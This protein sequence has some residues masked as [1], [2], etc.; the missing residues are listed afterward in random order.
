MSNLNLNQ[1]NISRSFFV[2]KS[3]SYPKYYDMEPS[4]ILEQYN[5]LIINHDS[6]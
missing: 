2:M 6:F 1:K 4:Q 5:S 3:P